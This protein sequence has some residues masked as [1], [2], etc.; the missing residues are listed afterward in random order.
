MSDR[1]PPKATFALTIRK[2]HY[3]TAVPGAGQRCVIAVALKEAFPDLS[4]FNVGTDGLGLLERD[5]LVEWGHTGR[6]LVNQFDA[7][8]A[9]HDNAP[10][11]QRVVFQYK[12]HLTYPEV[13]RRDGLA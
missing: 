3:E 8:F 11:T 2:R 9:R 1:L 13:E 6:D 4:H 10:P 5:G 12:G 7:Q